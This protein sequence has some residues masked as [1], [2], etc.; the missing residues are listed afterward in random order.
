M[1]VFDVMEEEEVVV[2]LM[3]V[4]SGIWSKKLPLWNS[5]L[6][7]NVGCF[8]FQIYAPTFFNHHPRREEIPVV[9]VG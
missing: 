6:S 7:S 4:G 2:V 1:V 3:N 8:S 5:T 9:L